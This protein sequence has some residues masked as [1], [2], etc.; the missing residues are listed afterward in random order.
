MCLG[1]FP[2]QIVAIVGGHQR[3]RKEFPQFDQFLIGSLL[4]IETVFHDLEIKIFLSEH[5]PVFFGHPLRACSVSLEQKRGDF[6][7]QAR[8]H[9]DKTLAVTGQEFL[10]H[11]GLVVKPFQ[12]S[13]GGKLHEVFV[14]VAV[15][16]KNDEVPVP[17]IA[18][19]PVSGSHI[20]FAADDGFYARLVRLLIKI[21]GAEHIAV[22]GHR[23]RRHLILFYPFKKIIEPD[24]SIEK[25]ILGMH[26]KMNKI[27]IMHA[28]SLSRLFL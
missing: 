2:V 8:A 10:V 19:N 27:G 13:G 5:V 11:A 18:V 23:H 12:I 6:A 14:S 20:E 26:M 24:G 4:F 28:G 22:I 17:F 15:P 1:V 25:A 21:D 3:N 7:V 16:G 9:A